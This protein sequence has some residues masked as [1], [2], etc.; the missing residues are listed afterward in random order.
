MQDIKC[1]FRASMHDKLFLV[2]VMQEYK[3][4]ALLL[5]ESRQRLSLKYS[6]IARRCSG[7]RSAVSRLLRGKTKQPTYTLKTE[8]INVIREEAIKNGGELCGLSVVFR[9]TLTGEFSH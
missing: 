6:Q 9:N 5:N 4:E 8:V 1:W 3:R 7:S 2:C